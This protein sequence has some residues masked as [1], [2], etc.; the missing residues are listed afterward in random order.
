MLLCDLRRQS[1]P[2]LLVECHAEKEHR[3]KQQKTAILTSSLFVMSRRVDD[4][5]DSLGGSDAMTGTILSTT[6]FS[7]LLGPLWD[8]EEL[9]QFEKMKENNRRL[10]DETRQRSLQPAQPPTAAPTSTIVPQP[11]SMGGP[12]P[13]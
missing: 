2:T 12:S 11:P 10:L 4:S 8:D 3:E 9:A 5:D 6:V 7:H 13:R 1:I